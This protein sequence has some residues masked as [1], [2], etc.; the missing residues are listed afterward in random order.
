MPFLEQDLKVGSYLTYDDKRTKYSDR[1]ILRII[2][3]T[4]LSIN[5]HDMFYMCLVFVVK[6]KS[7]RIFESCIGPSY[8]SIL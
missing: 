4:C 2:R 5:N 8:W 7:L 6:T 1:I 3:R